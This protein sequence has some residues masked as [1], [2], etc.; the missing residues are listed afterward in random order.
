MID[1][2]LVPD[3]DEVES[4]WCCCDSR[5]SPISRFN[6]GGYVGVGASFEPNF[7]QCAHHIP[8]HVVEEPTCL[9]SI[10][11][12]PATLAELR[13]ADFAYAVRDRSSSSSEPAEVMSSKEQLCPQLHLPEV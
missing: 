6:D 4:L 5:I 1:D 3:P 7:Q 10:Y 11:Q 9:Y 8:H 2:R 12:V 13:A